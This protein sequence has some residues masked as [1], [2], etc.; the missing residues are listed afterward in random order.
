MS[1]PNTD[2]AEAIEA[3]RDAS[4]YLNPDA[5]VEA[6][7]D[8]TSPLHGHFEWNDA[9]ASK[10][11]RI[12]QARTLIRSMHIPYRIGA[13][14]VSAVAYVPSPK[15]GG[16]YQ[17]LDE[18]VPRSETAKAVVLAEL[19][20]VSHMLNR[21]RKIAAV[22]DLDNEVDDLLDALASTRLRIEKTP[23]PETT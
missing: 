3:L 19:G 1:D 13:T 6:A 8:P 9:K 5:V 22:V 12:S 15:A 11:Y 18:I 16:N 21:A 7:A 17:R 14:L 2:V 23:E 20:R 10:L 4:G